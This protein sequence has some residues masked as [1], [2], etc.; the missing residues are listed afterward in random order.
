MQ[1]VSDRPVPIL[2]GLVVPGHA[3]SSFPQAKR[4]FGRSEA[5]MLLISLYTVK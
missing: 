4:P 1:G 2:T 5:V 3:T